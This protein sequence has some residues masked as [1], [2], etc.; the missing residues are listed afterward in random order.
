MRTEDDIE[1]GIVPGAELVTLGGVAYTVRDLPN[2]R[3]RQ[4]RRNIAHYEV[5]QKKA[6]KDSPDQLDLLED[7]MDACIML[8]SEEIEADWDRIV[9]TMTDTERLNAIQTIKEIATAP[10]MTLAESAAT[11]ATNRATRRRAGQK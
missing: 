6:K 3:A 11:P 9:N 10:F 4:I 7:M 8:G 2:I 1:D 5:A